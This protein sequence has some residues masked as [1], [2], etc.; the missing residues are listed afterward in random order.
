MSGIPRSPDVLSMLAENSRIQMA[1][2]QQQAISNPYANAYRPP[3]SH[4]ENRAKDYAEQAEKLIE[5][6]DFWLAFGWLATPIVNRM[7]EKLEHATSEVDR[8]LKMAKNTTNST[9]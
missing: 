6:I 1:M 9:T 5:R 7:V 3:A 2:F 8:L 4:Y